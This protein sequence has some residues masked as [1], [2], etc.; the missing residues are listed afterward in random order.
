V[1]NMWV[2]YTIYNGGFANPTQILVVTGQFDEE[3]D[4]QIT[5]L[6]AN[7]IEEHRDDDLLEVCVHASPTSKLY[8]TNVCSTQDA[9]SSST[10]N[11]DLLRSQSPPWLWK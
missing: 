11:L 3:F 4:V 5:S 6:L 2:L 1:I 10:S 9:K 8:C 7:Y